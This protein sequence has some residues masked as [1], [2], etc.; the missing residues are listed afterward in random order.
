MTTKERAL[1]ALMEERGYTTGLVQTALLLLGGRRELLDE[2][3][4]FVAETDASKDDVVGRL[5]T[6]CGTH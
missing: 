5:A 6:L 3:I 2:L 4:A 1:A